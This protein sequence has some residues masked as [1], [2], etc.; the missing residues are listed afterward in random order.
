MYKLRYGISQ[1]SPRGV[2]ADKKK[3]CA[4]TKDGSQCKKYKG[5]GRDGNYCKEHSE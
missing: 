3:C 2:P 4:E 1:T 5:F